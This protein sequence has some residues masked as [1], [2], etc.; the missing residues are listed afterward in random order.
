MLS[1]VG[2]VIIG[3]GAAGLAA[4]AG[5][6]GAPLSVI[7]LEARDRVGGR[8]WT[9]DLEG[10]PCDLGCGWLHSADRNLFVD[11][12][13]GLDLSLDR[14][15]PHR[16]RQAGNANF[17][18]RDQ[19]AFQAALDGLETR[20]EAA[21]G[22]GDDIAVSAL[23]APD[24]P[25]NGLL[26]AFSSYYNGAEFDLISTVDYD[27]YQDSGVNW[28]APSGYGALI[29]R[30]GGA[31][32]VV[33]G[34]PVHNIDRRSPRLRL[35]GL[36]GTVSARMAILTAPTSLIAAGEIAFTPD[37]SALRGAAGDLPLGLA[38]KVLLAVAEPEAWPAE[39]HLFGDPGRTAT[40]SY[41]LRPFG[42]PL[43]EVYFGGR[44]A[45]ALEAEGEGAA[46]AFAIEELAALAGTGARARLR[47]LATTRW[48]ADPWAR[49]SYSH[50][51]PGRASARARLAEVHDERIVMAGEAVSPDAFSTAHGAA[52][53]GFAAAKAVLSRLGG[54]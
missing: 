13:A 21:A 39:S 27:A 51:L 35:E 28:R 3:A 22:Q 43:I 47:P 8:A 41:H 48:A 40:G 7:V 44:H 6:S 45:A 53:T 14:T 15:P 12:A 20:I 26:D 10:W 33:C 50:A 11:V 37:L 38:D 19:A 4:A 34:A 29:A 46:A 1:E 30:W 24:E 49:G 42:R 31:A 5:L 18:P 52:Q 32:P 23:M 17:P 36:G 25:W 2:V 9:R 16:T 54:S